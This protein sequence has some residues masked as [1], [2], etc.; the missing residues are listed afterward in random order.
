MSFFGR[1]CLKPGV[2][3]SVHLLT[4]ALL[5]TIIGCGLMIRGWLL[6]RPEKGHWLVIVAL[7]A[8][9]LKSFFVLDK[10]ARRSVQRIVEFEDGTCFGAVYSWK[11]WVLVA[12]MIIFGRLLRQVVE[13]GLVIGLIYVAVGWALFFSSRHGWQQWVQWIRHD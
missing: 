6:I 13:P 12:C 7:L 10:T 11:T 9:T 8:G 5:W 3:R 1:L 4:A 2:N